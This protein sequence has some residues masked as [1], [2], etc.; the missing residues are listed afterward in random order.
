[1]VWPRKRLIY[2]WDLMMNIQ[3]QYLSFLKL[4][5]FVGLKDTEHFAIT[6][7]ALVTA[8]VM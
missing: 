5:N 1:M 7:L 8:S 6:R 4:A 3:A 2:R